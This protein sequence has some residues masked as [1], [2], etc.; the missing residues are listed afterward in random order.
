MEQAAGTVMLKSL[1]NAFPL[2]PAGDQQ[3]ITFAGE[4]V[5]RGLWT[6][7]DAVMA[8]KSRPDSNAEF[9]VLQS[10]IHAS[11]ADSR[12]RPGGNGDPTAVPLHG[13]AAIPGGPPAVIG[14]D[15]IK[16]SAVDNL[17]PR[18]LG[19]ARREVI[20]ALVPHLQTRLNRAIATGTIADIDHEY[21]KIA[22]L[23]EGLKDNPAG[24]EAFGVLMGTLLP[25][26][27]IGT[28]TGPGGPTITVAEAID[29]ARPR[30]TFQQVSSERH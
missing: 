23:Q 12:A 28:P 2:T 7:S 4:G 11:A 27:R 1:P 29:A 10:A 26:T 8:I 25:I 21:G 15:N 18:S 9:L 14:I 24:S 17:Q 6:E 13:T 16:A 3:M 5:N 30:P 22:S 19:T 20:E